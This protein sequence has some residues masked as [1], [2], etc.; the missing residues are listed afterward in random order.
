MA[1][2]MPDFYSHNSLCPQF[3]SRKRDN[4]F[5]SSFFRWEILKSISTI[6]QHMG[7]FSI[8]RALLKSR[9][10]AT[11]PLPKKTTIS[12]YIGQVARRRRRRQQ[13]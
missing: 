9:M 8:K 13:R 5:T 11:V 4:I 7:G 12:G 10:A 6:L 1:P 3:G 2:E